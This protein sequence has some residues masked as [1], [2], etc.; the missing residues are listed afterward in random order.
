M[1][2]TVTFA[3]LLQIFQ[4]DF[5]VPL[6][7]IRSK[8]LWNT[9]FV[10]L[11]TLSLHMSKNKCF[12]EFRLTNNTNSKFYCRNA[13]KLC[14]IVYNCNYKS[15]LRTAINTSPVSL[16]E[17]RIMSRRV[18]QLVSSSFFYFIN[19][20][21]FHDMIKFSKLNAIEDIGCFRKTIATHGFCS[22]AF[23]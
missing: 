13:V 7:K 10:M 17:Y 6:Y 5:M 3:S 22:W 18:S 23:V 15:E 19:T 20:P 12:Y 9:V 14:S 4:F 21:I 1:N 16:I 2:I 8:V 11:P